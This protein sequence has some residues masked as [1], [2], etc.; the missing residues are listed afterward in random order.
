MTKKNILI[1]VV[2][3][4]RNYPTDDHNRSNRLT[5]KKYCP[6]CKQHVLH[7]ESR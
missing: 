7:E 4:N 3:L 2:C 6:H 5:L 1:C